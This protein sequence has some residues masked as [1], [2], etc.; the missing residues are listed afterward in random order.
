[1]SRKVVDSVARRIEAETAIVRDNMEVIVARPIRTIVLVG[2]A[3]SL[4]DIGG[5]G[6]T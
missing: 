6:R 2:R 5:Q 3:L 4:S 1:M